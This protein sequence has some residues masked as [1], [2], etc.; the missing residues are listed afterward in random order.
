MSESETHE[1]DIHEFREMDMAEIQRLERKYKK[2]ADEIRRQLEK[3]N[4]NYAGSSKDDISS[5]YSKLISNSPSGNLS[6][7]VDISKMPSFVVEQMFKTE[8]NNK[9]GNKKK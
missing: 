8:T 6:K 9:K 7:D 2:E 4:A 1:L 3:A 5:T